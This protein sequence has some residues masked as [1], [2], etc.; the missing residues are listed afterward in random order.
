MSFF[1]LMNVHLS[2]TQ[3]LQ[4]DFG[5]E[6]KRVVQKLASRHD[7]TIHCGDVNGHRE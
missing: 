7:V 1:F 5:S 6:I 3:M 4:I 2:Q